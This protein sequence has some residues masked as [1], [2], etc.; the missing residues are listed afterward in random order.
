M[1]D[2]DR[3]NRDGWLEFYNIEMKNFRNLRSTNGFF[4]YFKYLLNRYRI[5]NAF[6][7]MLSVTM[8]SKMPY[9]KLIKVQLF[10]L[11]CCF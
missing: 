9:S 4:R 7:A 6:Y 5:F 8:L 3:K 11:V 1:F 10:E 2:R